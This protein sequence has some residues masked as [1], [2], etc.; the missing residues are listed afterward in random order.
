MHPHS[1]SARAKIARHGSITH[2]RRTLKTPPS[3]H[4]QELSHAAPDAPR[5][6]AA[7]APRPRRRPSLLRALAAAYGSAYFPLA[8]LKAL[9]DGLMLLMPLLLKQLVQ[10][11]DS[12]A[13][14]SDPP[15]S[16]PTGAA[17]AAA[18][19]FLGPNAGYVWA[20]LLA[21]AAAAKAVLGAHYEY[22]MNVVSNRWGAGGGNGLRRGRAGRRRVCAFHMDWAVAEARV[23][24]PPA[25]VS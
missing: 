22:R 23:C 6:G 15:P 19:V 1:R 25:Q 16:P 20:G 14:P 2:A 8:L 24:H 17:A 7:P 12:A 21:L 11:I 13:P 4:F 10:Q 9:N 5:F 3:R 18:A